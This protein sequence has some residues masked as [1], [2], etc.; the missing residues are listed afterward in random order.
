MKGRW[1]KLLK[2]VDMPVIVVEIDPKSPIDDTIL[3]SCL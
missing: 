2:A 1:I 3:K